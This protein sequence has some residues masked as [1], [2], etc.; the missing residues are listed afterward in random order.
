MSARPLAGRLCG[1]V[2]MVA[3]RVPTIATAS[4]VA[5]TVHCHDMTSLRGSVRLT[6]REDRSGWR[7]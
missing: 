7:G 6:D 5:V 4:A 2:F 1:A 3:K